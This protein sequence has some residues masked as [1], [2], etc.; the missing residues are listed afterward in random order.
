GEPRKGR[1]R[2]RSLKAALAGGSVLALDRGLTLLALLAEEDG[3][4]LTELSRRSGV[5]GSTVHRVLLTLESRGFVL[6]D[7]ERG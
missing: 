1:G 7:M 4:T 6:H 3:L 2:P 5:S